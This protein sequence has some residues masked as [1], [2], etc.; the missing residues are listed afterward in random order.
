[1]ELQ[2]LI[3]CAR[4]NQEVVGGKFVGSSD[5][6]RYLLTKHLKWEVRVDDAVKSILNSLPNGERMHHYQRRRTSIAGLGL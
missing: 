2:A 1:M 6:A 3:H 4:E 5:G